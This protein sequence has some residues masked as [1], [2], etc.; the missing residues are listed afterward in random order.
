[1]K[2]TDALR[3][4]ASREAY[5]KA[6]AE[7]GLDSTEVKDELEATKIVVMALWQRSEQRGA[8]E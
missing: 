7:L 1:M 4:A 8:S 5:L 3:V 6:C 2:I